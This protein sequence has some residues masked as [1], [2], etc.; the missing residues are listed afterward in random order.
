MVLILT[1]LVVGVIASVRIGAATVSVCGFLPH[2]LLMLTQVVCCLH[3][4]AVHI[5]LG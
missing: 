4:V 2:I 1:V 3:R 5:G